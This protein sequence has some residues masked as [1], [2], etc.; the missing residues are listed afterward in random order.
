MSGAFSTRMLIDTVLMRRP[1]WLARGAALN[2]EGVAT[3]RSARVAIPLAGVVVFAIALVSERPIGLR[4]FLFAMCA[5]LIPFWLCMSTMIR[6][7]ALRDSIEPAP[8]GDRFS[9]SFVHILQDQ[10]DRLSLAAKVAFWVVLFMCVIIVPTEL[11][12]I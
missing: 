9:S 11:G 1:N 8:S 4:C 3:I 6:G 5:G 12:W 10:V 7:Y 2:P